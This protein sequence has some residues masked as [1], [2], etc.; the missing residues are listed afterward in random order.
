MKTRTLKF[1]MDCTSEITDAG[2]HNLRYLVENYDVVLAD[3]SEV[4]AISSAWLRW[5]LMMSS[6]ANSLGHKLL[7]S[8]A[9]DVIKGICT[10][11]GYSLKF[12]GP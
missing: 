1:P 8:G 9:S 7:V 3:F 2:T 4:K 12:E 5:L 10:T 6:I 11:L